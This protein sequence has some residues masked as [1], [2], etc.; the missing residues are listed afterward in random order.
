[1]KKV[2]IIGNSDFSGTSLFVNT[3]DNS[4]SKEVIIDENTTVVYEIKNYRIDPQFIPNK[5][6][7]SK[8]KRN[9]KYR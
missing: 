7:R 2:A 9:L 1:M 5:K 3:T 8:Y 4:T 6:I